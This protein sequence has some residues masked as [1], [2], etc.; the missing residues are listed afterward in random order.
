MLRIGTSGWQY[1]DWRGAFYPQRAPVRRWLEEYATHFST[2]EVNNT[3]YRL[4]RRE[5]FEQWAVRVPDGFCFAVKASRYLTHVRRLREPQEPVRR[6]LDAAAGLGDRLGPVLLQLPPTLRA[7]PALLD[8]TLR[9]FPRDVRVAVEVRHV[10]WHDE[11]VYEVL[12]DHD[13]AL[14]LWDRRGRRGPVVRTASWCF[15]RLHEGTATPPPCFGR[16]ALHSWVDR[17]HDH[18][19]L[20]PDGYVYFNNDPGACAPRNAA[21]FERIEARRV[22]RCAG[23]DHPPRRARS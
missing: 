14:C 7:D 20:A 11:R 2:V 17:L 13:A 8:A 21:T 18:W 10:S 4:P 9:E 6:L 15:L 1:A 23:S 22:R 19:G 16:T 5:T 3:F 12:A